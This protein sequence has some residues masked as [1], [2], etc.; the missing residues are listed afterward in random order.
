M[1]KNMKKLNETLD[2]IGDAKMM[3]MALVSHT[4]QSK[5]D[6]SE[7]VV[8]TIMEETMPELSQAELSACADRL[9]LSLRNYK[10]AKRECKDKSQRYEKL[11]TLVTSEIAKE[12]KLLSL[13]VEDVSGTY[14]T[15]C[16]ATS[17]LQ[18]V[19][20]WL[21]VKALLY[22][23][24]AAESLVA[25]TSYKKQKQ[26]EKEVT[27]STT[28]K[29]E[30]SVVEESSVE[31]DSDA[32]AE[33]LIKTLLDDLVDEK[34]TDLV[35][36]IIR[37]VEIDFSDEDKQAFVKRLS[38]AVYEFGGCIGGNATKEEKL[39][40][41]IY[42]IESNIGREKDTIEKI[43][44]DISGMYDT[45]DIDIKT[46]SD[47]CIWLVVKQLNTVEESEGAEESSV[48]EEI[49]QNKPQ[50]EAKKKPVK[51]PVNKEQIKKQPTQYQNLNMFQARDLRRAVASG[52]FCT[53]TMCSIFG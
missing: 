25:A 1:E 48:S 37:E 20:C 16:L 28:E 46:M 8:S 22:K 13:I 51:F 32:T 29:N 21:I 7:E 10:D 44:S 43:M 50:Y 33:S 18:D 36:K 49:P 47:I 52:D 3:M 40:S 15:S 45:S 2:R 27:N 4:L 9:A 12:S 38:N 24:P 42:S 39:D 31:G 23:L 35:H 5:M 17:E 53:S 14:D 30:I 11:M 26:P 6:C 41:I 19:C 34:H